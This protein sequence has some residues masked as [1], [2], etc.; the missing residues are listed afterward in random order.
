MKRQNSVKPVTGRELRVYKHQS[1]DIEAPSKHRHRRKF[2]RNWNTH[3]TATKHLKRTYA[4][5][6]ILY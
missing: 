3:V 2:P 1:R 4:F 5:V 6:V